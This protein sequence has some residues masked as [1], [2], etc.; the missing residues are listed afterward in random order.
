MRVLMFRRSPFVL[1]CCLTVALLMS[2]ALC[3]EKGK[4]SYTAEAVCAFRSI[5]A[6]DTDPKTRN[7]DHMAKRFVNYD[8]MRNLPG[9][10]LEFEDAKMAMDQMNTGVFYYVNARTH[11][12]DAMLTKALKA[13]FTQVVIMG[14]G[15]D[16]RAYRFHD[17]YPNVH[18]FEID[19]PATS[20]DKQRRVEKILGM[21]P[22][23]VTFVPI[24]FNT[25]TLED[26]LGKAGFKKNQTTF[27]VWEGVTYFISDFGVDSTLRFIAENSAPGS[28]IVFDYM[29]EDVVKGED[30]TPYGARRTVFIVA[31]RGEPYV[32]GIAPRQLKAFV[33]LRGLDLLSDLGPKGL[34][35]R[36]LIQSDGKVS[37]RISEFLRIVHAEVPEANQRASLAQSARKEMERFPDKKHLEGTHHRVAVPED[38]QALLDRYCTAVKNKDF[39]TLSDC[40]SDRYLSY[41][42]TRQTVLGWLKRRYGNRDVQEYTIVLTRLRQDGDRATIDGFF[43]RKGYRTPLMV[44]D[45]IREEDGRWRWYGNQQ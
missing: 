9:L 20:K 34:T 8:T 27:Y 30:Y 13:G 23:W 21:R 43:S 5:A 36:Y 4:T 1:I 45:L 2:E 33:N 15:F 6:L 26:V 44:N 32:F 22:D 10:G 18:F 11:H 31:F 24:D 7:P 16:S 3:V 12:M 37:G 28:R 40:F 25:Q 19:L 17:A 29:L 35:Q 41:G 39:N 38:I 14:A 42:R